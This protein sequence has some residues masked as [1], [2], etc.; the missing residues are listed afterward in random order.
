MLEKTIQNKIV[1]YLTENGYY[2][3]KAIR[4]SRDG[5]P[6]LLAVKN[7]ITYFFEV[8]APGGDLSALQEITI[9][10]LNEH[11]NIAFVVWSYDKFVKIWERL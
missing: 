8:K 9:K 2:N 6:D 11:K 3:N 5:F 1:K 4:M 7:G 10:K